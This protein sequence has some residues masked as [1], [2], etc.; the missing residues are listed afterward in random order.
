MQCE[1][2]VLRTELKKN[3]CLGFEFLVFLIKNFTQTVCRNFRKNYF[4]ELEK[5]KQEEQK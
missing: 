2:K 1:E 4:S 3:D 5:Y